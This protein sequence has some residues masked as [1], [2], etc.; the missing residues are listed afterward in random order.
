MEAAN[1]TSPLQAVQTISIFSYLNT[2][3]D[4]LFIR[5][6]LSESNQNQPIPIV[7]ALY[8]Y[9]FDDYEEDRS[10]FIELN[11]LTTQKMIPIDYN[12]YNYSTIEY[13]ENRTKIIN[14]R[15]IDLARKLIEGTDLYGA[16]ENEILDEAFIDSLYKHIITNLVFKSYTNIYG[17]LVEIVRNSKDIKINNLYEKIIFK[18][19]EEIFLTENGRETKLEDLSVS[20]IVEEFIVP[21]LPKPKKEMNLTAVDYIYAAAGSVFLNSDK[22]KVLLTS[23][24]LVEIDFT[25][26]DQFI[27]YVTTAHVI[28]QSVIGGKIDKSALGIFGLPALLYY[29]YKEK[30][31]LR[32]QSTGQIINNSTLR[33]EAYRMLFSYLNKTFAQVEQARNNDY[34]YQ[35]YAALSN[36]KNRTTLARENIRSKCSTVKDEDFEQEVLKY[37]NNPDDYQCN[38]ENGK[39]LEDVNLLYQEQVNNIAGKYLTYE[40]ES[41]REAFGTDFIR[42]VDANKVEISKGFITSTANFINYHVFQWVKASADLFQFKFMHSGTKMY[43]AVLREDN[44]ILL[45]QQNDATSNCSK[46]FRGASSDSNSVDSA[47]SALAAN[48]AD[49]SGPATAVDFASSTNSATSADFASSTNSPAST[50]SVPNTVIHCNPDAF[51]EKLEMSKSEVFQSNNFPYVM[52]RKDEKFE[53]F[54]NRIAEERA[55]NFNKSLQQEGYDQTRKEWWKDFGLSLLPFYTCIHGI[56]T[57]NVEEAVI[58][59]SLDA[60]FALPLVEEIGYLAEKLTT[61]ITRSILS[62]VGTT[63]GTLTLKM[64]IRETL[65]KLGSVLLIQAAELSTFFSRETFQNVGLSVLRYVD[66]GFELIYTIG[67]GGWRSI[68]TTISTLKKYSPTFVSLEKTLAETEI[69]LSDSLLKVSNLNEKEVYVNSLSVAKKSGYGYQFLRLPNKQVQIRQIREYGDKIPVVVVHEPKT[70][71][72]TYRAINMDT[73]RIKPKFLH[74]QNQNLPKSASSGKVSIKSF[75]NVEKCLISRFRRSPFKFFCLRN[76]LRDTR[77]VAER[78]AVDYTRQNTLLSSD[79]VHST[80]RKFAFP[81]NGEFQMNF[82]KDWSNLQ[83]SGRTELPLWSKKYELADPALFEKLRYSDTVDK[84]EITTIEVVKRLSSLYPEEIESISKEANFISKLYNADRAY[85]S[86][87]IEDYYAIREYMGSGYRYIGYNTVAARQM[88][89]AFYRLAIRQ[90]DDPIEEFD[91]ILYRGETRTP[92]MIEKLFF[93]GKKEIELNRFTSTSDNKYIAYMFQFH[94]NNED[95]MNVFYEIKFSQPFLRAK[96]MNV[97]RNAGEGETV[98]LPGSKFHID[99]VKI[100]SLDGRGSV[101]VKMSFQ[102]DAFEKHEWYI[103]IMN[104]LEKLKKNGVTSYETDPIHLWNS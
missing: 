28:E 88:Q 55:K 101:E 67:K 17:F 41:I 19:S 63:F 46:I 1:F 56:R 13:H 91:K 9:I 5:N 60:L 43:F 86:V 69:K 62:S 93:T 95:G 99:D 77:R 98:L 38:N 51:R 96:I 6:F 58:G 97:V 32:T 16:K 23:V 35:F 100:V 103:K 33:I 12:K 76:I 7:N 82:V 10:K 47:G 21:L 3:S 73:G 44:E 37:K 49:F 27:N 102:H 72:I 20:K 57:K 11:L 42:S 90:S 48:T 70:G 50:G 64:T 26:D 34:R 18:L 89:G 83:K 66:P 80:L 78:I 2:I 52:K 92:E 81:E 53:V 85:E 31:M 36:F 39:K 45:M 54:L 40:K 84:K 29:V 14:E 8:N 75:H 4:Y 68:I 71:E 59:C 65:E 25:T 79:T 24:D 30:E 61:T 94:G 87:S 74:L 22:E 104:E 15:K